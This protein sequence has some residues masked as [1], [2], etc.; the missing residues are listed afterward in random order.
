MTRQLMRWQI[1]NLMLTSVAQ[2]TPIIVAWW[3]LQFS[4]GSLYAAFFLFV[5]TCGELGGILTASLLVR[6]LS[7]EKSIFLCAILMVLSF[8]L[9]ALGM[10]VDRHSEHS[11]ILVFFG[12][13][14]QGLYVGWLA[15]IFQQFLNRSSTKTNATAQV[16]QFIRLA[17]LA[18]V[19]GPALAGT[20]LSTYEFKGWPI[21]AVAV[22]VL[23][24]ASLLPL[25]MSDMSERSTYYGRDQPTDK[26]ILTG[27]KLFSRLKPARSLLLLGF[28][29]NVSLYVFFALI[30]PIVISHGKGA[31]PWMI[32]F[33]DNVFCLF[34]FIAGSLVAGFLTR[35]FGK[36]M[37]IGIS[38]FFIGCCLALFS[39]LAI[40]P[41][42][43]LPFTHALFLPIVFVLMAIAG[44]TTVGVDMTMNPLIALAVPDEF[45]MAFLQ[46]IAFLQRFI[47]MTAM[48]ILGA[49]MLLV[50]PFVMCGLLGIAIVGI[51]ALF[52]LGSED[53]PVLSIPDDEI[54]GSYGRFFPDIFSRQDDL[55]A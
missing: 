37:A 7:E 35:N 42:H 41:F 50:P 2:A 9:L 10:S 33:I 16:K 8:C 48:W 23:T 55:K 6:R 27:A 43:G 15:P 40:S 5:V 36:R 3:A 49:A 34:G 17:V 51:A 24:C 22:A 31:Q 20:Y 1:G 25:K 53:H 28:A 12:V 54:H 32:G 14:L 45:R 13:L 44:S 11:T 29:I 46:F 39:I 21:I 18:S 26:S 19:I 52:V 4:Q 38:I 47:M 30:V